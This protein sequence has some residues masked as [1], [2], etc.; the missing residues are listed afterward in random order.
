MNPPLP[1]VVFDMDGVLLDS[2]PLWQRAEIEVFATVGVELTVADCVETMGRRVDEVVDHW[3]QRSPWPSPPP[4]EVVEVL[5]RRVRA[6]VLAEAEALPGLDRLIARLRQEGTALAL[7]TSSPTMLIDAVL[8][9]FALH[10]VFGFVASA[11]NE[12]YGKP[13]PGV[14][15]SAAAGL[16]VAPQSCVAIEDSV[17]GVLAA[18]AARMGCI[19]VPALEQRGD[20]RFAIADLVVADLGEADEAL[21]QWRR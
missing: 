17:T 2:E 21:S 12:P 19:A 7:A 8:E 6:L 1:A 14:Y 13:H 9:R 4:A 18:K 20:P 10:D 15:L 5:L 11:E 3:F 16:G